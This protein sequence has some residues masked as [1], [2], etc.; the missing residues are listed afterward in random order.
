MTARPPH[1]DNNF[2][3]ASGDNRA[4]IPRFASRAFSVARGPAS[5]ADGRA[6]KEGCSGGKFNGQLP[7]F[8]K[9]S[10]FRAASPRKQGGKLEP[11]RRSGR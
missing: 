4:F 5:R 3:T 2:T 9:F 6:A 7:D 11:K 10:T 1:S 8:G